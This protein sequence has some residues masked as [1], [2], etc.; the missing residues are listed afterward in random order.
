M[1]LSG[2]MRRGAKGLLAGLSGRLAGRSEPAVFHT[3]AVLAAEAPKPVQL[4][5]LADSFN[6]ATSVSYLEELEKRFH[7]DPKSIDRTW[8]AFFTNLGA[9]GGLPGQIGHVCQ[10]LE[11]EGTS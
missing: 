3:S 7:D 11:A 8:A 4:S 10:R 5:K 9:R 6:D 1:A 2:A